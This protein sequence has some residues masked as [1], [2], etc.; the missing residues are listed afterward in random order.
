MTDTAIRRQVRQARGQ[1]AAM[2]GSYSLGVFNDNFFKQ[3][4]ML[5][6]VGAGFVSFQGHM[7]LLFTA[8]YILLSA[9]FGWLADRFPKR[10]IIIAAKGLEV[11]AMICG[12][13]GIVTGSWLLI[14]A[15]VSTMGLQSAMFGPSLN[16]SIPEL[17]PA[18][19]VTTAN[20]FLKVFVTVA[21]LLGV[22]AAGF[23][24]DAGGR[25]A[26][27]VAA[28][29]IAG[30]GFALSF[31]VPARPAASPSATFP[32]TGPID[33]IRE[34]ARARADRLLLTTIGADTF[35]WFVG[36]LLIPIVNVLGKRQLGLS[37]SATSGLLVAELGGIAAGGLLSARVAVGRRWYRVLV[38]ATLALAAMLASVPAVVVLPAGAR[39][40][41]LLAALAGAGT[42]GGLFMIP[43]ESFIQ[44]RPPAERKGTVI[45]ASNFVIFVGIAASGPIANVLNAH[46]RPSTSFALIAGFALVVAAVLAGAIRMGDRA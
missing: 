19:H 43:C 32:W 46:V 30:V 41:L 27:A 28:L 29:A 42:A 17:Y 2:A 3:A 39:Y 24:L 22:A 14:L 35:V 4:A 9:P 6:A 38:P 23:L 25:L 5:L 36:S 44:V 18:E 40:W 21:I 37:D 31:A 26:I 33:S 8:P 11:L 7:L 45:A 10:R 1:F 15:M 20:G 16:G 12:A 34:L 13:V